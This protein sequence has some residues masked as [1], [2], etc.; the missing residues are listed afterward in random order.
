MSSEAHDKWCAHKHIY[1][2]AISKELGL[3]KGLFIW[4]ALKGFLF[5]DIFDNSEISTSNN[6]VL[7]RFWVP[8]LNGDKKFIKPAL[9]KV[10]FGIW[11]SHNLSFKNSILYLRIRE[12]KYKTAFGKPL[13]K[14]P[15]TP[16]QNGKEKKKEFLSKTDH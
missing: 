14:S 15:L 11:H 6:S 16:P 8:H 5:G 7:Q 1:N 9:P 10:T 3:L 13:I 2:N 4:R 12:I